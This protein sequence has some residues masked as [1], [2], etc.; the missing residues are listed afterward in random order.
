MKT[1]NLKDA[2]A[3]NHAVDHLIT[4]DCR[5]HADDCGAASLTQSYQRPPGRQV[6]RCCDDHGV[7]RRFP[8]A[9]APAS[10]SSCEAEIGPATDSGDATFAGNQL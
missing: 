3:R 2:L 8:R 5:R 10:T 4:A 7:N 1:V 9:V 6:P